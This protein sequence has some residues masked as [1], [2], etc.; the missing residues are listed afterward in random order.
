MEVTPLDNDIFGHTIQSYEN[1]Q[2]RA[3]KVYYIRCY[4]FQTSYDRIDDITIDLT[5]V[6]IT[7]SYYSCG[8][9]DSTYTEFPSS[10]LLM[11][12]EE[13]HIIFKKEKE[14]WDEQQRIEKEK[15]R[16]TDRLRH[17][18]FERQQLAELIKKYGI[19]QGE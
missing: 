11:S 4:C 15:I 1:L 16:E 19:P 13:L 14:D 12:D 6:S 10:Y 5:D 17:E 7:T 9:R 2:T 18:R 8:E 3:R